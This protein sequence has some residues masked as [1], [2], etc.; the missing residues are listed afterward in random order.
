MTER[1]PCAPPPWAGVVQF[2]IKAGAPGANGARVR[3][4]IAMMAPPPGGVVVLPEL[5]ATG[6][7]KAPAEMAAAAPK[8][9]AA[10]REMAAS[11]SGVVAGSVAVEE[12]GRCTNSLLLVGEDGV[13][14]AWPKQHLFSPMGEDELFAPGRAGS[15]APVGPARIGGLVCYDLRFAAVAKRLAAAGCGLLVVA[16]QWPTSRL[17]QWRLL[18]RA[19][20]AENQVYVA[21]ANACGP[22]GGTEAGGHSLIVA[23]DGE[24]MCEAETGEA[25][26]G[27]E[28]AP[29]GLV[30]ARSLF[31]TAG[32]TVHAGR[33]ADKIM[34]LADL[35]PEIRARQAAGGR[36]VFTN[37]CFD[38]LHPGHVTYLEE[39]RRQG[40][41]LVLGL[42]SDASIRRI[43]GP[44]RPVNREADRARVLA[45]LGCVD[46][47]TIFDEDTPLSLIRAVAPDVLVK[48]AD[49]AVED[50]V[51]GPEVVAAGGRVVTI[52]LVDNCSTTGIIEKIRQD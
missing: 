2:D 14:A 8:A 29:E 17:A 41:C 4:L 48:G 46:W 22:C 37:G 1:Q 36:V 47:V 39:A 5:W 15:A 35:L 50:I 42:N 32:T 9:I 30:A 6:F 11:F 28:L 34:A 19:R 43:K 26:G 45:A 24:V 10:M 44:A 25:A 21:A 18:L 40:D 52:P 13:I 7:M 12:E 33:D 16:A 49:W 31:S 38:I 23:P 27:T 51:G 3:E 20:A